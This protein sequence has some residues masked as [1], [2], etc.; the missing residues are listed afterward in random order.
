VSLTSREKHKTYTAEIKE[1]AVKL[2]N[3]SDQAVT[4]T[5]QEFEYAT[6]NDV[7]TLLTCYAKKKKACFLTQRSQ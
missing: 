2:A 3:E 4:K 6:H 1:T 5:A 7:A